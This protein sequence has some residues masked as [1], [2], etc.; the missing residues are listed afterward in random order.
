LTP[1]TLWKKF[2]WE[3]CERWKE[4]KDQE[5]IYTPGLP[6]ERRRRTTTTTIFFKKKFEIFF[7]SKVFY[8]FYNST[9]V[10]RLRDHKVILLVLTKNNLSWAPDC[11]VFVL[12]SI[13]DLYLYKCF[14]TLWQ[15]AKLGSDCCFILTY[16]KYQ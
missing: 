4:I 9:R 11:T 2:R 13:F 10:Y 8:F 6:N 3:T 16:L 7:R 5:R 1:H 14:V 12:V 15:G